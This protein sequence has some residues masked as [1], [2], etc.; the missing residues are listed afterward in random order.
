MKKIHILLLLLLL[1]CLT[2]GCGREE[3]PTGYYD[4]L[5]ERQDFYDAAASIDVRGNFLGM[6]FYQDEPVQLWALADPLDREKSDIYLYTLDG[7]RKRI[8]K[9]LR[10]DFLSSSYSGFLDKDGN[11][12]CFSRIN[13]SFVVIKTNPDGKQLYRHEE[14]RDVILADICQLADGRIFLACQG[15]G[16]GTFAYVSAE[17]DADTGNISDSTAFAYNATLRMGTGDGGLLCLNSDNIYRIDVDSGVRE[18]IWT[19]CGTTYVFPESSSSQTL[20]LWDFRMNEN[21]YPELLWG[22]GNG[23]GSFLETLHKAEAGADRE[24]IAVRGLYFDDWLL[25]MTSLFNQENDDYYVALETCGSDG[26]MD[27]YTMKAGIEV[28]AGKGPDIFVGNLLGEYTYGI[29]QKGGFV[30]LTPYLESSGIDEND[31]FPATFAKWRQG[32]K[33]YSILP[34]ID[35]ISYYIDGDVL[36]GNLHPDIDALVDALLSWQGN[37]VY[38]LFPAGRNGT[39]PLGVLEMLLQGS[40]DIWGAVDWESGTCD[41]GGSLFARILETAKRYGNDSLHN[42]PGLLQWELYNVYL[43]KDE[44]VREKEGLAAVGILFD[45]GCYPQIDPYHAYTLSVNINSA[46]K[47]GAWEFIRF[48]LGPEAQTAASSWVTYPSNKKIFDAVIA[49]EQAE[50]YGATTERPEYFEQ[51]GNHY[52]TDERVEYL[53]ETLENARFLPTKTEPILNII[54]EESQS[55]FAGQKDIS[56]ITVLIENRVQLYLD[57]N[58]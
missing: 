12:Y 8:M 48:L 24:I 1:C 3:A 19:F 43:Y 40:E 26:D 30:D 31:Y 28:A 33:I 34:S 35:L 50:G 23:A 36:G 17:L 51:R 20:L 41:F 47:D 56:E 39:G 45:D 27:D 9:G 38:M 15:T 5:S 11:L 52:L 14:D 21:G 29:A 53:K 25:K 13:R 44:T 22:E 7:E 10:D 57:E 54:Y 49:K 16:G 18:N 42:Y 32:D 6:Q 4:I 2:T 37:A 46:H 55:Y 58:R